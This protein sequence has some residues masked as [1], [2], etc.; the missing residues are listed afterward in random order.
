MT[1]IIIIL[2]QKY[3]QGITKRGVFL[4]YNKKGD[5]LIFLKRYRI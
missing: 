5:Y 3:I 1:D 2:F 4:T